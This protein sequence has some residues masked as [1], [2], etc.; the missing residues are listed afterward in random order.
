MGTRSKLQHH[1]ALRRRTRRLTP[2]PAA[3]RCLVSEC[4]WKC[5]AQPSPV[6]MPTYL[7]RFFKRRVLWFVSRVLISR[8]FI[9]PEQRSDYFHPQY[10]KAHSWPSD[11]FM[12]MLRFSFAIFLVWPICKHIG[13]PESQPDIKKSTRM[14]DNAIVC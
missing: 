9:G 4:G 10:Q 11:A 1:S 7:R 14:I 8:L 12:E 13:L 3:L 6:P 2:P 5:L